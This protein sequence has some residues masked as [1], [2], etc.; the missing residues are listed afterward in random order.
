V[1]TQGVLYLTNIQRL[2]ESS[3]DAQASDEINAVEAMVGPRVSRDVVAS[4]AEELFNR[5][6]SRGRVMRLV[7]DEAHHVWSEKLKWNQTIERLHEEL[8]QRQPDDQMAGVVFKAEPKSPAS[9]RVVPMCQRVH[10]VI[11]RQLPAGARPDELVFPGPGGSNGNPRGARTPLST[12]NLRRVY[13]AAVAAAARTWP[14]WTCA[15]PTIS[16]TRLRPGWRTR[17]SP[18]G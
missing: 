11:A 1:T 4:A 18:R 3:N 2:Y 16:A 12:H 6:A 15:A 14:T 9:V 7:I 10:Q 8:Q 5:V 13:Q 17:A